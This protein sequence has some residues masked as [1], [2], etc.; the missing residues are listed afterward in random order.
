MLTAAEFNTVTND[1]AAAATV[2]LG[3]ASIAGSQ[4]AG[5]VLLTAGVSKLIDKTDAG[6]A[7]VEDVVEALPAGKFAKAAGAGNL[8]E[9]LVDAVQILDSINDSVGDGEEGVKRVIDA[10]A[11]EAPY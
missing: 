3:T 9:K 1:E 4:A 5:A 6:T 7:D 2:L 8:T 10:V 11:E